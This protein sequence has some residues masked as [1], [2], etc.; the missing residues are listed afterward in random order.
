MS[1]NSRPPNRRRPIE[2]IKRSTPPG[3]RTS[4][5]PPN[6][7]LHFDLSWLGPTHE[8]EAY[9]LHIGGRRHLLSRHTPE[10]LAA[11]SAAGAP[12]HFAPQVAVQAGTVGLA[13]VT[14]ANSP[15]G[16]PTLASVC[17]HTAS[18]AGSYSVDDVAK[19][20][21]FMNPTVT[22]LTPELAQTVLG[23]IGN[24]DDLPGLT[25]EIK[26]LKDQWC[27]PTG[28]VDAVGKPVRKPNG[29]QY[30]TYELHP[31]VLLATAR[32][33]GQSKALIYS[34]QSLQGARWKLLPGV[35]VLDM[36]TENAAAARRAATA[37]V[38][39][40]IRMPGSGNG[41]H[42]A[43]QD[44]GP[45]Y[46]LAVTVKSL[47]GNSSNFVID[48][49][50]TNSYIRHT[51]VFVSFLKADGVTA[52]QVPDNDWINILEGA[53]L[54]IVRDWLNLFYAGKD[55]ELLGNNT[56]KFLGN[57]GAEGTFL[58]I[59]V[60]S[61][62]VEFQFG[63]PQQQGIVG[64]IRLLVGSL[65]VASG[66]DWDPDAAWLGLSMTA[67]I[68]LAIPTY[69][70]LLTV[71]VESNKIFDEI[72]K[73]VKFLLPTAN[74][75]Y[76]VA[77]DLFTDPS[78]VGKDISSALLSLGVSIAGKV[79]T[80][81]KVESLLAAY[82]GSEAVEDA[83]PFVGW[84]FQVLAIEATVVQL[85][86]TVGEVI[87]SPRVVEFDLTVTMDAQI[88]LIPEQAFPDNASSFTITAQYTGNTT[89]TYADTLSDA[90]NK[91]RIV[92]DWKDVPVGGQVSFVVAMFDNNGWGVGKGQSIIF[93][94]E[95]NGN[96][97]FTATVTVKQQ[98]YPL[99]AG[100]TYQHSALLNYDATGGY[101]WQPSV[102]AP[103]ETR[104]SLGTG[105][106]GHKLQALSGITLSDDL[107]VV[108][109]GW[110][111]SGLG[112][113]P[114]DG[115]G[116]SQNTE[117]YTMGNI[118]YRA[119]PGGDPKYWP[120]AGYM[121]APAG[122]SKPSIL[123]YVRTAAGAGQASPRFLYLDPSGDE[124]TG[125]HLRQVVPVID[126]AVP[127]NSTKRQFDL[128][129]GTSWG[130]FGMLPTSLAI[131]SNGYVVAVNRRYDTLQILALPAVASSDVS[132]PWASNPVGPGTVPG[133]LGAPALVAIRPDQTILVLEAGNRRIQAFSRGGHP[134]PAFPG[135]EQPYCIPLVSHGSADTNV[136]YLSMSVDVANYVYILSQNGNGYDAAD[137]NLDVY[138]PAGEH[139]LSQRGLVAA[140][141]AV[142][143]WRN[144]YTLNFQQISG[145]GGRTEPSI[146]EYTPSTPGIGLRSSKGDV[147]TDP[148]LRA[149]WQ[150]WISVGCD[151]SNC[152]MYATYYD[153]QKIITAD[154]IAI[155]GLSNSGESTTWNIFD[156]GGGKI[157]VGTSATDYNGNA[158]SLYWNS[159]DQAQGGFDN[160]GM[161]LWVAAENVFS[162][163][164]GPEQT[165]LLINM[166]AGRFAL[167]ITAGPNAG[168][169][170]TGQ[171]GGGWTRDWGFG[172]GSFI[173]T[174]SNAPPWSFGLTANSDQLPILKITTSGYFLN[175]KGQNLAGCILTD[176]RHCTLDQATLSGI[177]TLAG[178]NFTNA[179]LKKAILSGLDLA[180]AADWTGADFTDTDLTTLSNAA[181]ARMPG[182][183]FN[184][185][186]LGKVSYAAANLAGAHFQPSGN[187]VKANLNGTIF[188]G[189]DLTGADLTDALLVGTDFRGAIL[190]GTIF[191]GCD[192]TQALFDD[193]PNFTRATTGRTTFQG[194]TVPF[195]ILNDNWAYL[196]LT[197]AA[198]VDIPAGISN[199][200][201][202]NAL[203][204]DAL[205]LRNKDLSGASF[206]GARMY[207]IKLQSANLQRAQLQGAL[208]KSAVLND[209]N[210]TLGDLSN[211][212]LI[213]EPG[214]DGAPP[215]VANQPESAS[216]TGAF[217]FNTKLD[218]A[219]CDG[220]DFSFACFSTAAVLGS[221]PA[222]AVGAL[223]N[224]ADFSNAWV[225]QTI[226]DGAQL[227]GAK[228]VNAHMEGA[229]FQDNGTQATELNPTYPE[230]IAASVE[231]AYIYG[232]NFTGAN[233]DGLHMNGA[234]VATDT[235][236]FEHV[237]TAFGGDIVPVSFN[238]GPTVFGNTTS[239]TTCPNGNSGP[240]K[241]T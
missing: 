206:K 209:A 140:G 154:G 116:N 6:R 212:W 79:L 129:K 186:T 159:C 52:M 193:K 86:Q 184:G 49:T 157:A 29:M 148:P 213:V 169:Y 13:Y 88:T 240:C 132:A 192:L 113:P 109:Y 89:R 73:D 114:V 108:G 106:I 103:I 236:Q 77:K 235:G 204:P 183:I 76:T 101:S 229:S 90:K 34:D 3:T 149:T 179:S 112:I 45:N 62:N 70:L 118:G 210:L 188:S 142:D 216:L 65:G 139:L 75:V 161:L 194:A 48:L 221:Q 69:A 166:G 128:D 227:S 223:M 190:Q 11:S 16:F 178:A 80:D 127:M 72:F 180:K 233:M 175:L 167:Q 68:D 164:I 172:D 42:V 203:L 7:D 173:A 198:I 87:G 83:I 141:L 160:D 156:L 102:Q 115:P 191:N 9:T 55:P 5:R 170:L 84:A 117:L 231:S 131:H 50:V 95:L 218:G 196:D 225:V 96:P 54:P 197:L 150:I 120:D 8:T 185:A 181:G 14:G 18:D 26:Y 126:P 220:V 64:K 207:K 222:S 119:I 199:L 122:Y 205:D 177:D 162:T 23:H 97:I 143:L 20:V 58:G 41:Y 30:Y 74:A 217:M 19:A 182:T 39:A 21:V 226:F 27:Q 146:S 24:T 211:A 152:A 15:E 145:P 81:P 176:M 238:Y 137:F 31:R 40:D 168:R 138:T 10:T 219:H 47:S 100:T 195:K 208:L 202:D 78:K 53:T 123:L 51:S 63:L 133:R 92:V 59:P 93:D 1:T 151:T 165:F 136:V 57:V 187:G 71:G 85:A 144:V 134:V 125:Y 241:V 174:Q 37:P 2:P 230:G 153:N 237:F 155:T 135:L 158:I 111:A 36:K 107:G 28:V 171:Q 214:G 234:Y 147:A 124:N 25:A 12:T 32:P 201:A 94:N 22:L 66:G 17:I 44:G 56:L 200:M 121:T 4:S 61:A 228:F 35:S 33:S 215:A 38:Q 239:N 67:L 43:V 110:E 82:F 99:T 91:T 60:S 105:P 232:T 224:D 104:E 163:S 46:G 98:L 130:R 189:A